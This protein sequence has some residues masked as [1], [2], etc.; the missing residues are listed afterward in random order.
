MDVS[1]M[2]MRNDHLKAKG[3]GRLDG[4]QRHVPSQ[5]P[6]AIKQRHHA[7]DG[8]QYD[9]YTTGEEGAVGHMNPMQ[10]RL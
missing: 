10:N 8:E 7:N 3:L 9:S 5:I 4:A 2:G 6:E 1:K